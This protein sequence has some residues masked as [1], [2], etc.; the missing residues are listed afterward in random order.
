[1]SLAKAQ[2]ASLNFAVPVV[3]V[4]RSTRNDSCAARRSDSLFS[5]IIAAQLKS[6][7]QAELKISWRIRHADHAEAGGA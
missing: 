3:E 6:Q 4:V 5:V 2:T 1:M 7:F